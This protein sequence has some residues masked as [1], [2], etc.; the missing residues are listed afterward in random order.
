MSTHTSAAPA[1]GIAEIADSMLR[2][3]AAKAA[4]AADVATVP[5]T[6]LS[7]HPQAPDITG[8][9]HQQRIDVGCDCL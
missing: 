3:V 2:N 5:Q 9:K 7:K 6:V 1:L 4:Y 8:H